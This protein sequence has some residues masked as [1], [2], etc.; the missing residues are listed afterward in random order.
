MSTTY[1]ELVLPRGLYQ[2]VWTWE[3]KSPVRN[4][5]VYHGCQMERR[6]DLVY[7]CC[8]ESNVS[9]SFPVL[10]FYDPLL[11]SAL[12]LLLL[13]TVEKNKSESPENPNLL[14]QCKVKSGSVF[15]L[16]TQNSNLY[17]PSGVILIVCGFGIC[18][19]DQYQ[20]V[21]YHLNN[22]TNLY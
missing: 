22:Q 14:L 4:E 1:H 17:L 5:D 2:E 7:I 16:R 20:C 9:K 8:P 11:F 18:T 15:N 10:T 13:V 3:Q 12:S 19:E 6:R 21:D